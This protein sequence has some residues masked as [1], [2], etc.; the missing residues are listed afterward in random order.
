MKRKFSI[1]IAMVMA[2]S[3]CLVPAAALA[4]PTVLPYAQTFGESVGG[5]SVIATPGAP[6]TVDVTIADTGDGW[7]QW[8]YTYPETPPLTA[9]NLM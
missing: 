3:L 1:L 6:N 8:T 5:N 7:L 9:I 2:I 4:A